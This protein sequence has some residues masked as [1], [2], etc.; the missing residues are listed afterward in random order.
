[1]R[2]GIVMKLSK[3]SIFIMTSDG[4]FL[5]LRKRARDYDV[6]ETISFYESEIVDRKIKKRPFSF[7]NLRVVLPSLLVMLL[8]MIP[9]LSNFSQNNVYAYAIVDI[10]P[11]LELA[12][13]ENAEVIEIYSYN[14]D[15]EFIKNHLDNWENQSLNDVTDMIIKKSETEGFLK[16]TKE[17]LISFS[18]ETDNVETKEKINNEIVKLEKKHNVGVLENE[19]NNATREKAKKEEISPAKYILAEK[20]P[21]N[22]QETLESYKDK[23][24]SELA[25]ENKELERAFNRNDNSSSSKDKNKS[26]NDEVKNNAKN[27]NEKRNYKGRNNNKENHQDEKDKDKSVK[28]KS[29]D[30]RNDKSNNYKVNKSPKTDEPKENNFKRDKD[31]KKPYDKKRNNGS[32][33]VSHK[34]GEHSKNFKN[35]KQSKDDVRHG[36]HKHNRN[37]HKPN[38]SNE[39]RKSNEEMKN[40]VKDKS[41]GKSTK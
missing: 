21:V 24:I 9:L 15:G 39:D 34:K 33:K 37:N 31:V 4:E 5:K 13:N 7:P 26:K 22:V 3:N 30:Q 1:M 17:I 8:V 27:K 23:S 32:D 14:D 41:N 2:N 40:N 28:G 20:S 29:D 35:D 19:I 16:D 36:S 6:G 11:S 25:K 10:N 18:Y 12:L 38:V